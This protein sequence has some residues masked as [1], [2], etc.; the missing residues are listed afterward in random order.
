MDALT[1]RKAV[2]VRTDANRKP[3]NADRFVKPRV[4]SGEVDDRSL[5]TASFLYS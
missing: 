5:R 4:L 2:S 1:V 3:G